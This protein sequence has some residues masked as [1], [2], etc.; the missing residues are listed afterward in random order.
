MG[1][2][3]SCEITNDKL[4]YN[5]QMPGC[6]AMKTDKGILTTDRLLFEKKSIGHFYIPRR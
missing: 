1:R 4:R 3:A 6:S 5:L 2:L